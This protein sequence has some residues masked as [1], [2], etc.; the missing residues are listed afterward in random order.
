M[1]V[2]SCRRFLVLTL[3]L[4][5]AARAGSPTHTTSEYKVRGV[6]A[7]EPVPSFHPR[8]FSSGS[9]GGDHGGGYNGGGNHNDG[10]RWENNN[11]GADNYPTPSQR[12]R[13]RNLNRRILSSVP[14]SEL[15][16]SI[17]PSG[18]YGCPIADAGSLSSLPT[19]LSAWI[20]QG[21]ECVDIKADLRA[22]GG[23]PSLNAKHDCTTIVGANDIA[24]VVGTCVVDS[25][26]PGYSLDS[27]N[28][29]CTRK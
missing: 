9:G 10:G 29:A 11:G 3:A 5:S 14:P 26:L 21:F 17:C 7:G 16:E 24:C 28:N 20:E 2:F 18:L 13:A 25:C 12:P 23:C 15:A 4:V 22:C 6:P 8:Q 1:T 19:S 27:R